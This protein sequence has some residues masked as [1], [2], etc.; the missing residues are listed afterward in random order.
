MKTIFAHI[1]ACDEGDCEKTE[2]SPLYKQMIEHYALAMHN[3]RIF[4]AAFDA[5]TTANIDKAAEPWDKL[6]VHRT[7]TNRTCRTLFLAMKRSPPK[8]LHVVLFFIER[9]LLHRALVMRCAHFSSYW[10]MPAPQVFLTSIIKDD[11]VLDTRKFAV[12]SLIW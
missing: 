5:V 11:T 6:Q 4:M 10:E 8:V 3:T 7:C 12:Q 2:H 1:A 9:E